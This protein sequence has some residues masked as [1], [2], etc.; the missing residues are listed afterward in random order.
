[1][2]MNLMS[3]SRIQKTIRFSNAGANI[4]L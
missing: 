4:K 3:L 1:M 2:L